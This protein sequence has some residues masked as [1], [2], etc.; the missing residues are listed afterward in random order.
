MANEE[1]LDVRGEICPYPMLKTNK[2]LDE[3]TPDIEILNVITD[4][5]PCLMTIP[6]QALKR[7]YVC[8]IEEISQGEWKLHLVK[9]GIKNK[10]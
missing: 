5:S 2:Q 8:D 10:E 3:I 6:I 9:K 1:T 4:H 7:G